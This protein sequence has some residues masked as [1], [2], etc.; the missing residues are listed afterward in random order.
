VRTPRAFLADAPASSPRRTGSSLGLPHRGSAISK[1]LD[2]S[3]EVPRAAEPT[4]RRWSSRAGLAI[5]RR[6]PPARSTGPR[7]RCRVPT[8]ARGPRRCSA[9]IGPRS[10]G[11]TRPGP[12]RH[13][14]PCLGK[15][16]DGRTGAYCREGDKLALGCLVG[17]RDHRVTPG[18]EPVVHH[19][20]LPLRPPRFLG[21]HEGAGGVLFE[22]WP[23]RPRVPRQRARDAS[24]LSASATGRGHKTDTSETTR[25][26]SRDASRPPGIV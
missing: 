24:A 18:N 20:P 2:R 9:P 8:S 3:V 14:T 7:R 23:E 4:G 16:G 25:A 13:A 17:V 10:G 22:P 5:T 1:G 6:T 15:D 12:G 11:S 19:L 26:T 21:V